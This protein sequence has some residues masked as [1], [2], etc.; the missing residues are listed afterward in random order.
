MKHFMLYPLLLFA[1]VPNSLA[2]E[3]DFEFTPEMMMPQGKYYEVA[4]PDTL[5]L[6]ERARMAVKG[7][8][9]FVN[10]DGDC[11]PYGQAYFYCNPAYMTQ[12]E[13]SPGRPNWGKIADVM[14]RMRRMCG[15]DLNLD[16]QAKS[17]QEM[18]EYTPITPAGPT[19]ATRAMLALIT[20]YRQSPDPELRELIRQ[21]AQGH[22]EVAQFDGEY[23]FY[24]DMPED[25]EPSPLGLM[26]YWMQPFIQ[27]TA[28]RVL[29]EWYEETG[30]EEALE[31]ARK[32]VNFVTK[33]KYW[34][35]EAEPKA[36]YAPDR[37][38]FMGHTHAYLAGLMG[39]LWYA[40]ATGDE[41]LKEFSRSGYEY[42][43]N[44]GLACLGVFGEGCTTGDMTM[45]ALKLS[46][47]GVGDYWEDVDCYVRNHLI[48]LQLSEEKAEYLKKLAEEKLPD[49][50][51]E[52][53]P[54]NETADRV[55]ERNIGCI[56]SDSSQPD[57][58]V[59]L[60]WTI[61]C[62]GNCLTPIHR[63]W[64]SIVRCEDDHATINLLLNRASPWLDIDSYLPYEG[65]VVIRNK[66]AESIA[67]RIPQW[68]D[69][70]AVSSMI[71]SSE[72]GK[73]ATGKRAP[74]LIDQYLTFP[75]V[76]AEDEIV[77]A[78]P[79]R[80]RTEHYTLKWKDDEMW[81]ESTYPGEDWTSENPTRFTLHFRGNTL[82][83][84]SPRS[85]RTG[86][87]LYQ[88]DFLKKNDEAPM[89]TVTRFVGDQG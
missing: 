3:T 81:K 20:L 88:R 52:L 56:M 9:S 89:R 57:K 2:L 39:V 40:N 68:V 62:T 18:V 21:I 45:L 41:Q 5:D 24:Q 16:V 47:T 83:D 85:E 14:V 58:I 66:T 7:L 12:V 55:I 25:L 31:L 46:E 59:N 38:H 80:E 82:V 28:A 86:L 10:T 4:V 54:E 22:G 36:V 74:F 79:M 73:Q 6:A 30:D 19:P 51:K 61:C 15:S 64:E 35:P 71:N 50:E 44:F 33:D 37:A 69:L 49:L 63:V 70:E 29:T 75:D 23:A 8:T 76:S 11:E 34:K 32:L 48:E 17:F 13:G 65:K 87:P 27:G 42:M 78:F 60:L 67:V 43:R 1:L 53:D 26:G 72:G 77:I 84:L